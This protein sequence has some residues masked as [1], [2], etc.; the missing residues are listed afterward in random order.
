MSFAVQ[1]VSDFVFTSYIL[2]QRATWNQCNS[3]TCDMC[4]TH[5]VDGEQHVLFHCAN[6]YMIS[7][8]R[9]YAYL[10]PPTGAHDV[11]T[12]LSLNNNKLYF[13]SMNFAFYEQASASSRTSWRKAFFCYPCKPYMSLNKSGGQGPNR[14]PTFT[15]TVPQVL[16]ILS[17]RLYPCMI[18]GLLWHLCGRPARPGVVS[19]CHLTYIWSP[20]WVQ[21]INAVTEILKWSFLLTYSLK[22]KANNVHFQR[23][24][25]CHDRE[26]RESPSSNSS[27]D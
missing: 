10:F 22:K 20:C 12:C 25:T 18:H 27:S 17:A 3:P 13:S 8:C 24:S 1:L 23:K 14:S 4:D 11:F 19:E 6:P 5:G 16:I 7:L 26:Q 21:M 2:R 15:I 9:K